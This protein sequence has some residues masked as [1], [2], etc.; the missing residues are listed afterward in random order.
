MN[1]TPMK[2]LLP[3]SWLYG[4]GVSIHRRARMAGAPE[5]SHPRII[6]IGNLEAGGN[7]KTPLAMWLLSRAAGQGTACAYV[8]RGYGGD[9]VAHHTV[10]CVLTTDAAPA[11]LA[12]LRVMT[13][14]HPA[15]ARSVGDEGALVCERVPGAS[16]FFC[17][18]KAHAV[19]AA[20]GLGVDLVVLDDAFQSWGVA[21]HA[22]I[23]LL[24]AASPLDGGCLLPA[25]RL[26]E[27]P[28]A[29]L[30]AEAIVFNGAA[31]SG[32]IEAAREQVA[33]WLRPGVP[34]AGMARRIQLEPVAG[35]GPSHP[36]ACIAV[37]GIARP[38]AF[39]RSLREA[40]VYVAGHEVF[41]DHHAYRAR[42]IERIAARMRRE[43][44]PAVVTTEKDWVKLRHLAPEWPV[45]I[46]CLDVTLVGDELPG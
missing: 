15:L 21:R 18:D 37:S 9:S 11:S 25:G 3:L 4:A 28:D 2:A 42:D 14:E 10:T 27:N 30:R 24:D 35:G 1:P 36:E 16:A 17:S 31:T 34:V 5:A 40:D 46:A 44:V 38:D 26:R 29:L 39:E 22:D 43:G 6:S 23:V 33:R 12:G 32:A 45:W 20:A 19:Q 7:G 8:S 13:R 41:P